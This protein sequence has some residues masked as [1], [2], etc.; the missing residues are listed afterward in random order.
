[1]IVLRD[2]KL[3]VKVTR[4]VWKWPPFTSK[5]Q[6]MYCDWDNTSGVLKK[7]FLSLSYVNINVFFKCKLFC[8]RSVPQYKIVS[9]FLFLLQKV[10]WSHFGEE[11]LGNANYQC[12]FGL[13]KVWL[14]INEAGFLV[15]LTNLFMRFFPKRISKNIC[16]AANTDWNKRVASERPTR[17]RT[18]LN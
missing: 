10:I 7:I 6:G 14:W 3:V 17:K 16:S 12:N 18:M 8:V 4:K 13:N 11:G 1:M 2:I 9:F 5:G 15:V